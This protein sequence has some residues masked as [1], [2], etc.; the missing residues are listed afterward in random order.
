MTQ[1]PES[2]SAE[3]SSPPPPPDPSAPPPGYTDPAATAASSSGG[4]GAQL[5]RPVAIALCVVGAVLVG[6]SIFLNWA[7]VSLG[8]LSFTAKAN[9]VPVQF[10]VDNT[11]DSQDPS[12][13]VLLIPAAVAILA[14]IVHKVR[15]LAILG[16]LLAIVVAGL[17]L[18]QVN[19]GIEQTP[20][21]IDSVF[22]FIGI[23]PWFALVGGIFGLVGGL[24][25]KPKAA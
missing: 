3:P 24:I 8:S 9:S 25:P 6:V 20:E 23:A 14:G 2:E 19:D 10:L 21:G 18:F 11:T 13:L 15:W 5:G 12:L 4:A 22:D 16:G 17:Y 1:T 7:D